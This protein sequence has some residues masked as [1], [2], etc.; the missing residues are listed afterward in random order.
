MASF[1]TGIVESAVHPRVAPDFLLRN[2]FAT[3]KSAGAES[4]WVGDHLMS[5]FPRS[6]WSPEYTGA[7][8]LVPRVD[9]Y[10]E[11]WALLG[12]MAARNRL[13]RLRLGTAV[14]DTAR[15]N[16][17]VTAEAAATIH[18]LTRGRAILGIGTGER[19]GNE[20]YGVAWNRPV[21]RFE[22]ALATI[23]ALW[24]SKG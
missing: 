15:R 6:V 1:R 2:T 5:L 11:P 22:E 12:H 24:E 13:T 23:R 17:A 18:L 4:V 9:A 10:Y 21:A 20:P 3:T 8:R 7:A 14:T 19:E 16:P